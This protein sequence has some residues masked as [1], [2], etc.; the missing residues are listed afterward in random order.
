MLEN[1]ADYKGFTHK[2]GRRTKENNYSYIKSP[3][4]IAGLSKKE[5]TIL[6]T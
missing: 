6:L 5:H 1:N 3:A 2:N 4:T